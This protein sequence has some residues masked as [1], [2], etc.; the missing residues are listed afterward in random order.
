MALFGLLNI[1]TSKNAFL[2]SKPLTKG[3]ARM[4]PQSARAS[5]IS[6]L[7]E[8]SMEASVQQG[9]L[10]GARTERLRKWNAF[11]I[12][13]AGLVLSGCTVPEHMHVT[14]GNA[15]QN[16]DK[17][18]R[19]RTTYY[20]RVFDYC[21]MRNAK[22]GNQ[23]YRKIIP[24]TDTLYRYRMTGK[25]SA[26]F[27]DIKFESGTLKAVQIDPFGADVVYDPDMNGFRFR[28]RDKAETEKRILDEARSREET[29]NEALASFSEMTAQYDKIFRSGSRHPL[30]KDNDVKTTLLKA[31]ADSLAAFNGTAS[32]SGAKAQSQ[33]GTG[34]GGA[35]Q[36]G[37]AQGSAAAQTAIGDAAPE[38]D[39]ACPDG[40]R[41]QTGFQIMGP[42]GMKTF[43]QDER[44]IMAMHTS[45]KPLTETLQEYSGRILRGRANPAE[46]LLPLT[47][48]NIRVIEAQRA[49]DLAKKG[50]TKGNAKAGI[51]AIFN[52]ARFVLGGE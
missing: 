51:D 16:V 47:R 11:G 24:E 7:S 31:M 27:N 36:R 14:E 23:E 8:L 30:A 19:F 3:M 1:W 34:Q 12:I 43:D 38:S 26:L 45:A 10:I 9:S 29:R 4:H 46:Q 40:A 41:R 44:L 52:D 6:F 2:S 50:V 25:S 21:R 48:E 5:S 17:D 13:L 22:I 35:A 49:V 37:A 39:I 42:E 32:G 15:P 18:V 20:F 33:D 28:S